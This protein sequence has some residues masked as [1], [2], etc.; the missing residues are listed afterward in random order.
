[1]IWGFSLFIHQVMDICYY[2]LRHWHEHWSVDVSLTH[3][4]Y[5]LWL[6]LQKWDWLLD[7]MCYWRQRRPRYHLLGSW[8]LEYSEC[9][10]ILLQLKRVRKD[11]CLGSKIHVEWI[12]TLKWK[13]N[14]FQMNKYMFEWKSEVCQGDIN[15]SMEG[16]LS[17][18]PLKGKIKIWF[19]FFM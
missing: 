7:Q 6:Y 5:F 8:S 17:D 12:K 18:L 14:Q 19:L 2:I 16:W 4:F 15:V 11:I 13:N 3:C 9:F 1:M 10:R